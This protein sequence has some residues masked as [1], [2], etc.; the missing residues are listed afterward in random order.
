MARWMSRLLLGDL[1]QVAAGVFEDG[2]GDWAHLH[3]R[4]REGDAGGF[5]PFVFGLDVVDAE[6]G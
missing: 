6:R 5:Q 1:N 3:R 4:L 2:G